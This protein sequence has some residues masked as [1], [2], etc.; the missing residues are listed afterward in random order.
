MKRCHNVYIILCFLSMDW[1]YC[2]FMPIIVSFKRKKKREHMMFQIMKSIFQPNSALF[3]MKRTEIDITIL[4]N[5]YSVFQSIS[6]LWWHY[7]SLHLNIF[8]KII[9]ICGKVKLRKTLFWS[10]SVMREVTKTNSYA[11]SSKYHLSSML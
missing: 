8:E 10:A 7:I 2:F 6:I 5:H 1:L 4:V 3:S 11:N 9:T